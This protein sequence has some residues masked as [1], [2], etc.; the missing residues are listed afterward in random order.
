MLPNL[1]DGVDIGPK[2]DKGEGIGR[3]DVIAKRFKDQCSIACKNGWASD[4]KVGLVVQ[5]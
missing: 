4:R 5:G 1:A 3:A 2:C